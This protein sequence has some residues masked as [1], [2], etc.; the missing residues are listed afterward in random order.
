MASFQ[1]LNKSYVRKN[2]PSASQQWLES[3]ISNSII[4]EI[5]LLP[6]RLETPIRLFPRWK[7]N[8]LQSRIQAEHLSDFSRSISNSI[9]AK[10]N[11][12]QSRIQ[13]QS[14]AH[15]LRSIKSGLRNDYSEFQ[16]KVSFILF[17]IISPEGLLSWAL[18]ASHASWAVWAGSSISS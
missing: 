17:Q 9:D 4:P 8:H 11:H 1:S 3:S 7:M 10:A 5:N 18:W 15:F 12:P 16:I 2:S 13:P 6:Q 14:S